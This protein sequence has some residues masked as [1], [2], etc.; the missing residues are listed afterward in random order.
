MLFRIQY[1]ASVISSICHW[2]Q[3][4]CASGTWSVRNHQN[5]TLDS[6]ADETNMLEYNIRMLIIVCMLE[7]GMGECTAFYMGKANDG[8]LN[9]EY[10]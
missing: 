5:K 1:P 10:L 2:H 6:N 8:K 4:L 9:H 3:D 7:T